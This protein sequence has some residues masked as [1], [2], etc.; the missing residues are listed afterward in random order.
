MRC[1]HDGVTVTLSYFST[2]TYNVHCFLLLSL[3]Y[4]NSANSCGSNSILSHFEKGEVSSDLHRTSS[5]SKE[6]LVDTEMVL[7]ILTIAER[8]IKC[9]QYITTSS[10]SITQICKFSSYYDPANDKRLSSAK[11]RRRAERQLMPPSDDPEKKGYLIKLLCPSLVTEQMPGYGVRWIRGIRD[12]SGATIVISEDGE[13]YPSTEDRVIAISGSYESIVKAINVLVPDLLTVSFLEA[14]FA[15]VYFLLSEF[16]I[17]LF[18]L[19]V[20]TVSAYQVQADHNSFYHSKPNMENFGYSSEKR[21]AFISSDNEYLSRHSFIKTVFASLSDTTT[22][23]NIF[24][25][26][27]K[28]FQ[29]PNKP[30]TGGK[31][32]QPIQTPQ[33]VR[34]LIPVASRRAVIGEEGISQTIAN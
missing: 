15:V 14:L 2:V 30:M 31:Y 28:T 1:H 5:L 22:S 18:C 11:L 25:L 3:H 16:P 8:N 4:L 6:Y 26:C 10:G 24:I 20:A 9:L 21:A 34:I 13:L 33:H 23:F 17:A 19:A 32:P 12:Y 7:R 29:P 27:I